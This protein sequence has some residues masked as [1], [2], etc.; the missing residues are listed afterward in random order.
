[1]KNVAPKIGHPLPPDAREELFMTSDTKRAAHMEMTHH[2]GVLDQTTH[3]MMM[4]RFARNGVEPT[5]AV[6]FYQQ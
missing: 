5:T 1:M 6:T 2:V 4:V 3:P